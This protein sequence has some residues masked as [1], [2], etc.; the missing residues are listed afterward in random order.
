MIVGMKFLLVVLFLVF[1]TPVLAHQPLIVNPTSSDDLTIIENPEVSWAY[2]GELTGYPHTFEFRVDDPVQLD[3]QILE[4]DTDESSKKYS[5]III[6]E[7]DNG[8]GVEEIAR[9][10]AD[11]GQ[12]DSF[13]EPFGGDRY[14]NGPEFSGEVKPGV[15][16]IEVSTP[17]NKG[18]YALSVGKIEDFSNVGYFELFKT[19]YKVKRF[20]GKPPISMLGTPFVY[21][22]LLLVLIFFFG[23]KKYKKRHA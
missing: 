18:K 5:G 13:Y 23:W 2:Y 16:R 21:V 6:R 12:W 17:T 7:R 15:Y 11:S 8:R 19:I 1:A 9:L 10:Q 22:P 3:V 20:Q 14:L 4:F